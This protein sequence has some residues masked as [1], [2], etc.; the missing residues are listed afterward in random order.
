MVFAKFDINF[1]F[2]EIKLQ[3][4]QVKKVGILIT[5]GLKCL[6]LFITL[7]S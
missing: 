5:L 6:L 3:M 2:K 4:L 7:A 1:S